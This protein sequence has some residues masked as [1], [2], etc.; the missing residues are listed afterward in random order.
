M[1]LQKN[2]EFKASETELLSVLK[3]ELFSPVDPWPEASV[4]S[5][6]KLRHRVHFS[7][8][9]I[10]GREEEKVKRFYETFTSSLPGLK[11]YSIQKEVTRIIADITLSASS[12]ISC[13]GK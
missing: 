3:Y 12:R 4:I 5:A 13:T 8:L 2:S 7:S 1:N 6:S 11:E 10:T 9:D